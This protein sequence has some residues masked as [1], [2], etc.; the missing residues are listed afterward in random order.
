MRRASPE[1]GDDKPPPSKPMSPLAMAAAEMIEEEA[2]DDEL[3]AY[4]PSK[5]MSPLAMAAAEML[6]EEAEND[7]LS[8]YWRRYDDAKGSGAATAPALIAQEETAEAEADGLLS[9][10]AKDARTKAL[11]KRY[12]ASIGID[13]DAELAHKGEIEEAMASAQR[14]TTNGYYSQAARALEAVRPHLQAN[15]NL[16]ASALLELARAYEYE[17]LEESARR[18]YQELASHPKR[19]TRNRARR[20]LSQVGQFRRPKRGAW[21]ASRWEKW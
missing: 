17:E 14:A 21:W 13:P 5:P 2:E 6:E 11:L 3:S 19:D 20:R 4:K 8:A 16:G 7:E 18:I 9:E 1:G 12:H 15:S 10:E